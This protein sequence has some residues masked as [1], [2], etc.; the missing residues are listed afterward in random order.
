LLPADVVRGVADEH[1]ELIEETAKKLTQE[2]YNLLTNDCITKLGQLKRICKALGF[3]AGVIF[4]VGITRA[5]WFT[6]EM[7]SKDRRRGLK[8][9]KVFRDGGKTPTLVL[10]QITSLSSSQK[11]RLSIPRMNCSSAI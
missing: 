7:T 3:L 9:H 11:Y 6:R 4:C 5:E 2:P 1:R 10:C 8:E